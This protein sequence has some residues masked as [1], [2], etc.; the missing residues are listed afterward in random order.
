LGAV[1]VISDV[2]L[3]VTMPAKL[4]PSFSI[5]VACGLFAG[6]AFLEQPLTI[7]IPK[8]AVASKIKRIGMGPPNEKIPRPC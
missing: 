5:T 2:E 4:V 1:N 3:L 8:T 7:N 6:A